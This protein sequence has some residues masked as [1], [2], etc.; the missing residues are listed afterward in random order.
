MSE[1]TEPEPSPSPPQFGP[2]CPKCKMPSRYTT[3]ILD[4]KK[5]RPVAIYHCSECHEEVWT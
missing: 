3:S 2:P 5:D 4:V 1:I